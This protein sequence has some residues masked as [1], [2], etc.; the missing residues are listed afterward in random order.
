MPSH[1]GPIFPTYIHSLSQMNEPISIVERVLSL[2][3]VFGVVLQ[4]LSLFDLVRVHPNKRA[5]FFVAVELRKRDSVMPVDVASGVQVRVLRRLIELTTAPT[6][7][8][9]AAGEYNLQGVPLVIDRHG[10]K[11]RGPSPGA[12][13]FI[14]GNRVEDSEYDDVIVA[15]EVDLHLENIDCRRHLKLVHVGSPFRGCVGVR[16]MQVESTSQA[17]T[18]I[19]CKIEASVVAFQGVIKALDCT[20]QSMY[21]EGDCII[22]R[23]IFENILQ[24]NPGNQNHYSVLLDDCNL[25]GRDQN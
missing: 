25:A 21:T 9:L 10:I 20:F 13:C 23:C 24:L 5:S 7:I 17:L 15:N 3:D 8:K 4:H 2:G 18:L 6:T 22:Q 14:G 19:D 12:V 16:A 1:L 11:L